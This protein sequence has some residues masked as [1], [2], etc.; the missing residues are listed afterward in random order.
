MSIRKQLKKYLD[1]FGIP[2]VSCEGD[3]VR[4][5]RC[6]VTG[7]FKVGAI[8]LKGIDAWQNAARMMADGTFRSA[9]ENA[10]SHPSLPRRIIMDLSLVCQILY[11]HPSS[12]MFTRQPS[13]GW[14]IYHEVVETTKSFMRDLTVVNEEWLVELA[15]VLSMLCDRIELMLLGTDHTFTRSREGD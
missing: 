6:L 5:R 9:R 13:T 14:V 7:Y 4:L 12:V 8:D 2:I 10:V 11:V 3:A 15:W 1:R